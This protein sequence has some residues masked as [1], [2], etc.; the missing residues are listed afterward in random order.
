MKMPFAAS[1]PVAIG[2]NAKCRLH[3]AM[4]GVGS[5][6]ENICSLGAFRILT[7]GCHRAARLSFDHIIGA[8]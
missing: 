2:T 6:A 3:D 4:S 1:A 5:K 8:Y 7:G